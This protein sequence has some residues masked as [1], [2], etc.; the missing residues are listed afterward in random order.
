MPRRSAKSRK[1]DG[2]AK[3]PLGALVGCRFHELRMKFAEAGLRPTR[4]RLS[5][6][7]LLFSRGSR[8]LTAEILQDEA[9]ASNVPVSLATI[10]N[11]LHQFT[12]A[13]I[14]REIAV[15]GTRTYFDTNT[16]RHHHFLVDGALVDIPEVAIDLLNLPPPPA[17][18]AVAAVEVVVR[19]RDAPAA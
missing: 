1:I 11:N 17:G 8:H 13:G 9:Q 12:G 5:L 15:D 4:Q 2:P 18:K 14:L 16:L 6:G 3:A 7:W 10:Y 19:L